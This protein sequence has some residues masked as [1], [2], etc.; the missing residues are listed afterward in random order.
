MVFPFFI[1][2]MTRTYFT[3]SPEIVL[4]VAPGVGAG[5]EEVKI[6]SSLGLGFEANT[7]FDH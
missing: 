6:V 4:D 2:I 7:V 3:V 5:M 1:I